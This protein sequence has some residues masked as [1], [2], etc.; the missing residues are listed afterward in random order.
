MADSIEVTLTLGYDSMVDPALHDYLTAGLPAEAAPAQ[1]G[2]PSGQHLDLV[3]G[4]EIYPGGHSGSGQAGSVRIYAGSIRRG[5]SHGILDYL[6]AAPWRHHEAVL[7]IHENY[8]PA[9]IERLGY[10]PAEPGW[11]H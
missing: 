8:G 11:G 7:V 9:M 4:D 1:K 2:G 10:V 6:K 5:F 3:S